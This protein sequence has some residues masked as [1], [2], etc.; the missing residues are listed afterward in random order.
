MRTPA[1]ALIIGR[2]WQHRAGHSRVCK[3]HAGLSGSIPAHR[4]TAVH[5]HI[6]GVLHHAVHPGRCNLIIPIHPNPSGLAIM[7]HPR[8]VVVRLRA[9]IAERTEIGR[10]FCIPHTP[11]AYPTRPH[12]RKALQQNFLKR[13]AARNTL[14]TLP[15]KNL[16]GLIIRHSHRLRKLPRHHISHSPRYSILRHTK[17]L[18]ISSAHH[19]IHRRA[20][21]IHHPGHP[22]MRK[23]ARQHIS[24]HLPRLPLARTRNIRVANNRPP[25]ILHQVTEPAVARL[26]AL[27]YILVR[28]DQYHAHSRAIQAVAP[29]SSRFRLKISER[30]EPIRRDVRRN[31]ILTESRTVAKLLITLIPEPIKPDMR[32]HARLT[33]QHMAGAVTAD[34]QHTVGI[35]ADS[36]VQSLI[37]TRHE[38]LCRLQR[39]QRRS[40]AL[41]RHLRRIPGLLSCLPSLRSVLRRIHCQTRRRGT[42]LPPQHQRTSMPLGHLHR[43]LAQLALLSQPHHILR[44]CC[45]QR[46]KRTVKQAALSALR[47]SSTQLPVVM[48]MLQLRHSHQHRIIPA[49]VMLHRQHRHQL[50]ALVAVRHIAC[51]LE[52]RAQHAH[53]HR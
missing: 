32:S 29:L 53:A 48:P 10:P 47:V 14:R 50:A 6:R 1:L 23:L 27:R 11:V 2:T 21:S 40:L 17:H 43:K 3:R 37:E 45:I 24:V 46:R 35:N 34:P 33:F 42:T 7:L 38:S 4:R 36:I 13:H 49:A 19:Q 30:P 18:S 31:A 51:R 16:H 9:T 8:V 26:P 41:T 22:Q 5:R 39:T 15:Q 28:I 12:P 25:H 20:I 52:R 44:V